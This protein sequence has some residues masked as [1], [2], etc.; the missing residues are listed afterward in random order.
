VINSVL[1][2]GFDD[3]KFNWSDL[4]P[5]AVEHKKLSSEN[6]NDVNKAIDA[7]TSVIGI[8][9]SHDIVS[10]SGLIGAFLTI[11]AASLLG[12]SSVGND[13]QWVKDAGALRDL[14]R[15]TRTLK[16]EQKEVITKTL[17]ENAYAAFNALIASASRQTKTILVGPG[18]IALGFV[19]LR[20]NSKLKDYLLIAN[21][22]VVPAL[23]EAIKFMGCKVIMNTKENAH[24]LA[25]L[26][27]AVSA[28]K[29]SEL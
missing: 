16:S 5:I 19:A 3:A 2:L 27:L 22:P 7:N 4:T 17:G 15:V 14:L 29:A 25:E 20:S 23:T 28:V 11:D 9:A 18:A 12:K 8:Y 6:E 13:D 21:T 1:A 10:A 24:P 26:A